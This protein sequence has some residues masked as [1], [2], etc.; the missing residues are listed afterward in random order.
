ML[1]ACS[2][3]PIH[4][5]RTGALEAAEVETTPGQRAMDAALAACDRATHELPRMA[6]VGQ[7]VAERHLAGGLI[8]FPF[9]QQ[10]LSMELWGRSGGMI[11]VGFDRPF[12]KERSDAEKAMDVAI[13]GYDR[14]PGAHDLE[15]IGKLRA[16]GCYIIGFGPRD[17]PSLKGIVAMCDAW[18]DATPGEVGGGRGV[19]ESN[20]IGA[21]AFT[22]E[23][24]AALTRR[25]QMP[26]MWKSHAFE[27]A[28]E[29]N[30]RYFGKKQFHDDYRVAP[31]RATELGARY[32]E[33]ISDSIRQLQKQS[34]K[35]VDAGRQVAKEVAAGRKVI[36]AWQ[37]HMPPAYIG[38]FDDSWAMAMEM[39]PFLQSQLDQYAKNTPDEALVVA[40]G[41]HGVDAR[42]VAVWQRKKQRVI[43][44]AGAPADP[45]RVV[46]ADLLQS[47]DLG[48]EFGDAYLSIDGYPIRILP[49]SGIMQLVAYDAIAAEAN[50][51]IAR[52]RSRIPRTMP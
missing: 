4:W 3:D 14:P 41:Y 36:V 2:V 38:K 6:T 19:T 45:A 30:S 37:G 28:G 15:E 10:S 16:R 26:T 24:I 17:M 20:T 12:K 50:A 40:L 5:L 22:A 39:H 43:H 29:W 48:F 34:A 33:N 1:V 52:D 32:I 35:L 47:I 31:I 7:I 46:R 25:G 27:D 49:P 42:S 18:F 21:W 11:H 9:P 23:V 51:I 44:M 13:V 8:G